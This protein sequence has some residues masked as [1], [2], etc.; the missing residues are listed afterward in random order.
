LAARGSGCLTSIE[1]GKKLC[2]GGAFQEESPP[3]RLTF[4]FAWGEEGKPGFETLVTN[5]LPLASRLPAKERD[6]HRGG[7]TSA[8][9]RLV[10]YSAV[11]EAVRGCKSR[12]IWPRYNAAPPLRRQRRSPAP[13][14]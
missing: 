5:S 10:E 12:P 8:F 6:G 2:Q 7:W 1:P 4:T 9:D 13:L 3:N 14:H 11:C